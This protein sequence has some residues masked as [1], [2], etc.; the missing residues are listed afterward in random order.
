LLAFPRGKEL[1]S[2]E[3]EAG[4][5]LLPLRAPL[6]EL[7]HC[8]LEYHVLLLWDLTRLCTFLS[9]EALVVLVVSSDLFPLDSPGATYG[10][11]AGWYAV[12]LGLVVA[13]LGALEWDA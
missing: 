7:C 4:F 3:S 9:D 11:R 2:L 12:A 6:F 13:E 10:F 8:T 5:R 1:A